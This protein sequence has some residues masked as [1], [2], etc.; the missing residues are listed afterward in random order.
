ML[1]S[2]LGV[3]LED[4]KQL[5][6][7]PHLPAGWDGFTVEYRYGGTVYHIEVKRSETDEKIT[8]D[9]VVLDNNNIILL[10]DDHKSHQVMVLTR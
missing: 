9:N 10:E 6:L 1:E 8:V 4:G 3:K 2:L 7:T 5:K